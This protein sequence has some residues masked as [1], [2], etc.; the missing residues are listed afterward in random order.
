LQ[1]IKDSVS[2]NQ[3]EKKKEQ[4]KLPPK[5]NILDGFLRSDQKTNQPDINIDKKGVPEKINWR[6][7]IG[8]DKQDKSNTNSN[9]KKPDNKFVFH[10]AMFFAIVKD[11]I[12][13]ILSF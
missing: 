12:E 3:D 8:L 2:P 4:T 13:I 1:D 7:T 10:S 6:K 9:A 5:K 11:G